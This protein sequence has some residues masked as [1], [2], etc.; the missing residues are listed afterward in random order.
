MTATITNLN[1]PT[2]ERFDMSYAHAF[3]SF[4]S[5]WRTRR[6]CEARARELE[7]VLRDMDP[8]LCRDL[9]FDLMAGPRG[10]PTARSSHALIQ[11]VAIAFS[12]ED[13]ESQEIPRANRRPPAGA[14]NTQTFR[15][16]S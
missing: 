13:G 14:R 5:N 11:A 6:R 10:D 1:P 8:T 12:S 16:L 4:C 2:R 7:N 9:G 3:R 15:R